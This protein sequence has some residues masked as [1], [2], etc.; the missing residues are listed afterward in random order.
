M[1]AA[2]VPQQLNIL[3]HKQETKIH[4]QCALRAIQLQCIREVLYIPETS[5]LFIRMA[6]GSFQTLILR[7]A[8]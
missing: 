5:Y 3:D 6:E 1:V 8:N 7:N 2:K 4:Q